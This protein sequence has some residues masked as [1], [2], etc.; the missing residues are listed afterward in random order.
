MEL[1][2]KDYEW[3]F[4]AIEKVE[5][6]ITENIILNH[7]FNQPQISKCDFQKTFI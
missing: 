7:E 1:D 6:S 3:A 4:Q 2:W 5:E